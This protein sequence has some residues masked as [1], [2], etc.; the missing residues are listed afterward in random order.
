MNYIYH[1]TDEDTW[2]NYLNLSELTHDSLLS[3][4]FI[5]C[6][7]FEQINTVANRF[8]KKVKL[9][10]VLKIDISKLSSRV[11]YE[12]SDNELYPHIYGK[13][14]TKA[15]VNQLIFERINSSQIRLKE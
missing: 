10:F 5:H 13:I 12:E 2:K 8:F 11:I 7:D 6:C 15:I 3:E 4:G 1:I 14:E 9:L